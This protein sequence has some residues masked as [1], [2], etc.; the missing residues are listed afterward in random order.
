[1]LGQ[2]LALT[3]EQT[4]I[5]SFLTVTA[6]V[7]G[8]VSTPLFWILVFLSA[9]DFILGLYSAW[10][11]KEVNMDTCLVGIGN[12]VYIGVLVLVSALVDYALMIYGINTQG[13]FHNFI[14]AALLTKE[15]GSIIKNAEK[16]NLWVP[17]LFREA[18]DKLKEYS[19]EE[20]K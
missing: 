11:N 17:R 8:L 16:G 9:I 7:Y 18:R 2:V 1:M 6:Y 12:K 13:L 5:S 10:K 14:M 19:K 3:K 4:M 20:D 15:L